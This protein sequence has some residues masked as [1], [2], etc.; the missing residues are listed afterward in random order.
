MSKAYEVITD[1]IVELLEKGTV[2]WHKPW[3]GPEYMPKSLVSGKDYRGINS[4]LLNS[5][6]Y[7]SPYWITFKQAK[8]RKGN[9]RKGQKGYPCIFWN[10]MEKENPETGKTD[11]IPFLKYYTVFNVEQCDNIEYPKP[12]VPENNHSP[13]ERCEE[14]VHNM[15]RPPNIQHGGNAAKYTPL[16]DTVNMPRLGRFDSAEE[17]YSTLFHELSHSTGHE[18]RL[19]RK[20]LTE[21][22]GFGSSKYS[23]EELIAEMGSAFLCGMGGIENAVIDNSAS[24]VD[25]WMK[26]LRKDPRFIVQTAGQAQK[27]ADFVLGKYNS[28]NEI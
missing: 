26:R 12:D 18:K 8:D 22:A 9:V 14:I 11:N 3:G 16:S 2:P 27:A 20:T 21:L 19:G 25:H 6:C 7:D 17:Y 28:H 15:P 4:F 24:Y 13:I 23:Q 5:A 1:R 10:W